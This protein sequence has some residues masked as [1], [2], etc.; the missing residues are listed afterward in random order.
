MKYLVI[1]AKET[2]MR[3]CLLIKTGKSEA[4]QNALKYA[5]YAGDLVII[6]KLLKKRG[7]D[8]NINQ[9]MYKTGA[10]PLY[11]AS[12]NGNIAIVKVLI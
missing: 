12:Q 6:R 8:I 4:I 9:I 5:V 10:S 1:I 3:V 2:K 7:D 11:I